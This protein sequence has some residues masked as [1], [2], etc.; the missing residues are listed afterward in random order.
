MLV[1]YLLTAFRNI[2][3][4]LGY[5]LINVLGLA[6]GV[7]S[8]LLIFLVVRYELGYDAFYAKADRIYRVNHHSIDYNPRTSPAVAP[9]LR[10]D[11]PELEVAQF[12]YDNGMIKIGTD[13]YNE[14]NY[15]YA[16]EYVPRMFVYHWIAGNPQTALSAPNQIVLTERMARKYFGQK[17]A[18]GQTINVDNQYNCKVTGI[19]ED[20]PGNTSLPFRFLISLST[21][22]H[23]WVGQTHEY[24]SIPGGNYTFIALPDNYSI[25]R[26]RARIKPFLAKN[27]G[28]DIA[29]QATLI[30]QP[31]REVHFDQRYL[32]IDLSPTTSKQTYYALAGI[33]LFILI[34]ACINFINLATG[35]AVTR[36]REVGVRKVL[37]ARRPQ[38]IGQFLGETAIQVI[39][40]VILGLAAA[41]LL[42]PRISVWLDIGITM[43]DLEQPVIL[44]LLSGIT[45]F[46]IVVA[47]LYPAFV[48]SAFQP[49]ISLKGKPVVRP[50][51]LS[52]RRGLVILQ[53]GISQL[54]IIG[55]IIVARQMDFFQNRDLGFN[56]DFVISFPSADSAHKQV[57]WQQLSA[58]PGIT[59]ISFSSGAPAYMG[60]A[61]GFDDP[62]RGIKGENITEIKFVDEHYVRMFDL[63]MLAGDTIAR[64]VGRD[65][66]LRVVVNETLIQTLNIPDPHAA[67][68]HIFEANGTR[69]RIIGVV[70]DFQSES[71]HKKRRACIMLYDERNFWAA[72]VRLN[73]Y[74]MQATIGRI[75][76][77]W[78]ALNP[79]NLFQYEFLDDHIAGFYRQE[80]KVFTAFRMFSCIAIFIGC[81]GLYGL[82]AFATL[83]RTREVGI[84]KV[85]GA[86]VPDILLLFGRE[87]IVLILLAFVVAAP[88]AW[89]AMHNW[90][91]NFAYRIGIG[92]GTF[93]VS[94]AVSFVIAAF[95]ISYKSI[96]AA[97]AN[98]VRSLR[99]E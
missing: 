75:D 48:Q 32:F 88:V 42:V 46:I 35:Q 41:A 59:D 52:L 45:G 26:V 5:T 37:G 34:T 17:E 83:Q 92:W 15:A 29:N 18:I 6:L 65:S 74:G 60:N 94:L 71:K 8:C 91:D 4:H 76:K 31:L 51:G 39:A 1:N 28:A 7:A 81:L 55:T 89:L 30:L 95:T 78:S 97:V 38:L 33:A 24:F 10:H 44:V 9:A 21:L 90:L 36:A 27:W 62:D 86:S 66:I 19:I 57:L 85:L 99:A 68:G 61:T 98:P 14:E 77:I 70:Q 58:T 50:G 56:K 13:R 87:F 80:Q 93:F 54:M 84:R 72:S 67:I 69:C 43:K 49:V 47:G 82:I 64:L 2:R 23:T 63:R 12:F 40:A 20:L 16:D 11:F 3:R 22:S 73:P 53:F 96:M 79:D 25:E